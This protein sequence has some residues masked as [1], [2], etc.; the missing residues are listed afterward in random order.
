MRQ[1]ALRLPL[2]ILAAAAA[3]SASNACIEDVDYG[4]GGGGSGT[5]GQGAGPPPDPIP[6]E[7]MTWNVRNLFNDQNDSS[8]PQEEIDS[9][10]PQRRAE[11]GQVLSALDVDVVTLQEVEHAELLEE[12]DELELMGRYP[13]IT[14]SEG[15]DPRGIDV[16]FMSKYPFDQV[17]SHAGETFTQTGTTTPSYRFARDA[18]EVHLTINERHVVLIGVHFKAKDND[19]PDKRLAE[20]QRT[21]NI[22][23]AIASED[24]EAAIVV[25]G[26]FN[27]TPMTP[28]YDAVLQPMP[29]YSNAALLA[30][31][32]DQWTFT[33]GGAQELVD[34]AMM[35][36]LAAERV[37]EGNVRIIHGPEAADASDHAPV[38]V[39]FSMN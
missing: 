15:N 11:V 2:L 37:D 34:H 17:V 1:N 21:R 25:L 13:Y 22:A 33:F 28:P 29:S 30:P 24:P 26:D 3:L 16:G 27:D 19:D 23:N 4:E 20:A 5:G 36:P 7:V 18:Y 31:D 39:G 32:E 10:W 38:I 35:N 8:A 6:F 12:L 14:V 9:N